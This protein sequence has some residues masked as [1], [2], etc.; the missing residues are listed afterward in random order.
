MSKVLVLF[1]PELTHPECGDDA[2]LIAQ[3]S[4]ANTVTADLTIRVRNARTTEIGVTCSGL[5]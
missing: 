4:L 2:A 1:C 5:F 3:H